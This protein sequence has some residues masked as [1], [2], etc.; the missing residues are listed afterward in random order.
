MKLNAKAFELRTKLAQ[1]IAEFK[2]L[3]SAAHAQGGET[4]RDGRDQLD[5]AAC[6][7]SR[8]YWDLGDVFTDVGR[9]TADQSFGM[10]V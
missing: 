1:L 8:I 3:E 10:D 5:T 4:T 2:A 6:A 9:D 7:L